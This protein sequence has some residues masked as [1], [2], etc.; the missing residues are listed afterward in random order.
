M[1][2]FYLN[3]DELKTA[4]ERDHFIKYKVNLFIDN[5]CNDSLDKAPVILELNPNHMNLFGKLEYESH[6]GTLKTDFT[7]IAPGAFHKANGGYLV[8]YIE[9]LLR[10][11]YSWDILKRTLQ[12]KMVKLESLSAIKPEPIPIDIKIILIG[13]QHYYNVLFRYDDEFNKYFKVFVDFDNGMV[14]SEENENG[15][16]SFISTYCNS[17]N[18]KH[19]TKEAVEVVLKYSSRIVDNRTKLSTKFNKI[20]ELL[21]ESNLFASLRKSQYIQSDDVKQAIYEKWNRL[22]K[23]EKKIDEMYNNDNLLISVEGEK[24]GVI[25]AL[26]V[27]NMGEYSFGRPTVITVTTSPGNKGIIN[28]EREVKLS[29]SIHDKG[30]LI[31]SGYLLENFAQDKPISM[32]ANV[33]FEQSYNGVDGD[34]ASAAELCTLLSS[35]SKIPILQNYA[36]TGSIN[37][38]GDIQVVGGVTQK[39]EGFYNVCKAKGLNGKQGVILPKNN[40]HNLVLLDEIEEAITEG[41]FHIYPITKIEEAIEILTGQQFSVVCDKILNRFD[42][43]YEISK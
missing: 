30:V 13:N 15:V 9:Q 7:K 28:I 32:T 14:R 41:L 29:G 4:T 2:L 35:L 3:E 17:N 16:A 31:L 6:N 43:F 18:L 25:N 12:L 21:I 36:I 24:V 19:L 20:T 39:V 1:Y 27:I 26:S 5:S 42:H 34:S 10:N 38:K 22:N 11:P 8:L 40:L 33:C 37:Q 23:I